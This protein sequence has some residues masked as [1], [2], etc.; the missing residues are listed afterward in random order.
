SIAT[1]VTSGVAALVIQASR[2]GDGTHASPKLVKEI[3]SYT[4]TTLPGYDALTQGHGALNAAGAIAV[5]KALTDFNTPAKWW[6]ALRL[7]RFTV[8]AGEVWMWAQSTVFSKD[9]VK[10]WA[11]S[12][13]WSKADGDT[14]V[15][16][17]QVSLDGDTI[18]WGTNMGLDGDTIVWGTNMGLD[19]DTIVWGT[20][21]DHD[22]ALL[23]GTNRIPMT[24]VQ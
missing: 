21:L 3:L 11:N 17:T 10:V 4:A 19:G 13:D 1:A 20:T 7:N 8:V 2:Q 14:I 9:L 23:W 24:G 5:A 12:I 15:W 22:T 16:G 6:K 18:V